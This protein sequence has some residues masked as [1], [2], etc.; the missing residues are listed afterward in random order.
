MLLIT[1][2]LT[3][4]LVFNEVSLFTFSEGTHGFDITVPKNY[5]K[6]EFASRGLK[7]FRKKLGAVGIEL[8]TLTITG[9]KVECLS[10]WIREACATWQAFS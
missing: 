7:N 5:L 3:I 1:Y 2:R 4:Q 10:K 8:T 9:F 6:S